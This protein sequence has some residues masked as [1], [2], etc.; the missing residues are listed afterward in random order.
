MATFLELQNEVAYNVRTVSTAAASGIETQIKAAI[1]K[2]VAHYER[3]R[4]YFNET[5][6]TFTTVANQEYYSSSD[7]ANI[8]N[9]IDIDA[10]KILV[11]G[12]TYEILPKGFEYLDEIQTNT[13]YTGDPIFYAYY[14]QQIRFYP[15]PQAVRTVTVAG[16][17]KYADLS[18][19]AD[20]NVF[21]TEAPDLIRARAEWHL[22]ANLLKDIEGA[23]IAKASENDALS[24]ITLET[25]TRSHGKL[26]PTKF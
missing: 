16:L 4:F 19:D 12:S 15:V 9:L 13:A 22:Y 21:T 17:I 7:Q 8:P 2:A 25:A 18:A 5:T 1:N 6:F 11:N 3:Q 26:R 20:Y 10:M 23:T 24:A 14:K